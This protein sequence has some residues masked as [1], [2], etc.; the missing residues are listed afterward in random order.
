MAPGEVF[1]GVGGGGVGWMHRM[2]PRENL[3][4]GNGVFVFLEDAMALEERSAGGSK[5]T[6][7]VLRLEQI[8]GCAHSSLSASV[9]SLLTILCFS[10]FNRFKSK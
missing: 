6:S 2:A 8:G 3:G 10:L 4:G 5:K 7:P 1:S 9:R